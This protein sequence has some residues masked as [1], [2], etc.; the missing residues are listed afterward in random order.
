MCPLLR[1]EWKWCMPCTERKEY[2]MCALYWEESGHDTYPVV[3]ES[4]LYWEE[5]GHDTCPVWEKIGYD[6]CPVLIGKWTWHMPCSERKVN[7]MCSQYWEESRHDAYSVLRGK[8]T[9]HIPYFLIPQYRNKAKH[10]V[11]LK[12]WLAACRKCEHTVLQPC[13]L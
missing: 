4:V 5:C 11:L 10:I 8:W 13:L 2:M 3:R 6:M 12:Y 1:G 9:W 7:M